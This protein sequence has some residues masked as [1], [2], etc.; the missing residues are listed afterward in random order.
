MIEIQA[1]ISEPEFAKAQRVT[2]IDASN[3]ARLASYIVRNRKKVA[4]PL[5]S[6]WRG[7]AEFITPEEAK[8]AIRVGG[9]PVEWEKEWGR[10]IGEFVKGDLGRIETAV[11]SEVG[12]EVAR[13]VNALPRKEF[14]FGVTK[15]QVKK[16]I[17]DHGAKL[18]KQLTDA[19]IAAIKTALRSFISFESRTPYQLAV[20]LRNLVGLGERYAK[21]V[22]NLEQGLRASGLAE[23][24]I[25]RQVKEYATFLHKVRAENIARTE[26]SFA[27]NA[28]QLEAIGQAREDGWLVG[29][30]YKIWNTTGQS[31]RVCEE[32]EELDGLDIPADG[33]FPGGVE[34]PPLHPQ[35]GCGLSYE[36]RR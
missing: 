6:L 2:I 10:A 18:I 13:R 12:G 14:V 15:L 20:R 23:E 4:R 35:C 31:G 25:V 34:A 1:L 22:F 7:M 24:I 30:V 3:T 5:L 17:T 26:L 19:Q 32:C 36:T 16:R 28:G 21:A 27:Y 8:R 9:V 11:F 33:V 29:D